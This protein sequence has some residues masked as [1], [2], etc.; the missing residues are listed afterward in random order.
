MPPLDLASLKREHPA[1]TT[2]RNVR[3]QAKRA[4]RGFVPTCLQSLEERRLLSVT[5]HVEF[6]YGS[7]GFVTGP[8]LDSHLVSGIH[9]F[10]FT[11]FKDS[12]LNTLTYNANQFFPDG[13]VH[14]PITATI[15]GPSAS[16][17]TAN[18][19][20]Q[21]D[22]IVDGNLAN[23]AYSLNTFTDQGLN[24]SGH[25]VVGY[26]RGVKLTPGE[27]SAQI[28]FVFHDLN[29]NQT[30]PLIPITSIIIDTIRPTVTNL[31]PV[32]SSN[33][34]A[35]DN[36]PVALSNPIVA[37]TFDYQALK[38]SRSGVD[39]PLDANVVV[40][41]LPNSSTNFTI[42]G[43]S[44]FTSESG[45]YLLT[46]DPTFLKDS[47]ANHGTGSPTIVA[48]H[49]N[50]AGPA[51]TQI[52]PIA[53]PRRA[54]IDGVSIAFSGPIDLATFT[55][56]HLSLT[57]DGQAIP[58]AGTTITANSSSPSIVQVH[59]LASLTTA[60]GNYKLAVS[61]GGVTSPTGKPSSTGGDV[62]FTILT[63][64]P[65]INAI[66]IP[67]GNNPATLVDTID[68][69][70]SAPINATSFNS[71]ALSLKNQN[72]VIT[73]NPTFVRVLFVSSTHYQI[74]GL[75]PFTSATGTYT[76]VVNANTLKSPN[77]EILP[78][79]GSIS[80]G[81][82]APIGGPSVVR[83]QRTNVAKQPTTIV[84]TLDRDLNPNTAT[85]A[86]NFT[87][88]NTAKRGLGT[89]INIVSASYNP[90]THQIRLLTNQTLNIRLSYQLFINGAAPF[91][92][93][94]ALGGGLKG[95][96]SKTGLY[97]I[98]FGGTK[99]VVR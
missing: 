56:A 14:T 26:T 45:D 21:I 18:N 90:A 81:H 6:G 28:A 61:V 94:D 64:L 88:Y 11:F 7:N 55:T 58:L 59:G 91:G 23:T 66:T 4:I 39:V 47:A 13:T 78:T 62:S 36:I 93:T 49:S 27:H 77:G 69:T 86:P 84:I 17:L 46:I 41:P 40:K 70:F 92:L 65:V 44:T 50:L 96:S 83:V 87:L 97:S 31:G 67:G 76:L 22:L 68:V 32:A 95:I 43:L 20:I 30:T 33:T 63:P 2:R 15:E 8:K 57:R 35:V 29:A 72:T 52:G 73:L 19:G 12:G 75:S 80:F 79:T 71:L 9:K 38:L 60:P 98:V 74:T 10:D 48:F 54:N 82:V 99:S 25:D 89:K 3:T 5:V 42:T 34:T 53:T 37:S 85:F 24:A 51:V 1:M 16:L